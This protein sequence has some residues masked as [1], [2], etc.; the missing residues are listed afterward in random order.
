MKKS[1]ALMALTGILTLS[2]CGQNGTTP[3]TC[4]A[5]QV[6][7]NGVCVTPVT[8]RVLTFTVT[9]VSTAVP[10]TVTKTDGT[11]VGT[12]SVTNG[13]KLELPAGSYTVTP[14]AV[15]GYT[16]NGAQT[17]NLTEGNGTVTLAYAAAPGTQTAVLTIDLVG[18]ATAPVT[19]KDASGAVVS[20]Y[21]NAYV[22]DGETITLARGQYT[23]LGG[24]TMTAVAPTEAKAAD[25]R[26]GNAT[27][28]L[29]YTTNEART[30][31][32]Y[33]NAAGQRVYFNADP[34][35]LRADIAARKFRFSSWLENRD[36]GINVGNGTVT[37]VPTDAERTEYA[38]INTQNIVGAYT[39]YNDNGVWRPVVNSE[40]QM[41]ILEQRGNVRFA[42]ADDQDRSTM[43]ALDITSN[44]LSSRS[45][46][47]LSTD[48]NYIPYPNSATYPAYNRTGVAAPNTTGYTW[49]ALN[50]DPKFATPGADGIAASARIRAI[51]FV[52]GIEI[53]KQFLNKN[54]VASA[55]V[56]V[57]K[58]VVVLDQ[59]Q[60]DVVVR[61][62]DDTNPTYEPG[63]EVGIRI[64]IVN[65]GQAAANN[66]SLTDAVQSGDLQ[67]YAIGFSPAL[68]AY[69]RAQGFTNLTTT[70]DT[71]KATLPTLAAGE[72]RSIVFVA[73]GARDGTYCDT[74]T[75]DSYVNGLGQLSP[76]YV[77]T[78]AG[79][80]NR[81]GNPAAGLAAN[82][83]A[84]CFT[85]KG[86]PALSIVKEL[87]DANGRVIPNNTQV[88]RNQDVRIR[89]T[90]RN[91]GSG[92]AQGITVQDRLTSGD[93]AAHS[94]SLLGGEGT[95]TL[96]GNDGFN[97]NIGSLPAG[98]VAQYTFA[99]RG[100]VD[101]T[102]CDT[103]TLASTNVTPA[104]TTSSACFKVATA[105]LEISKTNDP[106]VDL[107]G[108]DSYTSTI[109]VRNTGTLAA[110]NIV[111]RDLLGRLNSNQAVQVNF[112]SGRYVLVV[113]DP[114]T[115]ELREETTPGGV[116]VEGAAPNA[117][118]RTLG[119]ATPDTGITL[120]PG[121]SIVL[122]VVS[123]IPAGTA[124]G[125]YCNVA[126]VTAAP[127]VV[128]TNN[129]AEACVSIV[130]RVAIQTELFDSV[131]L[132]A[133]AQ[134]TLF[135]AIGFNE[136]Q[137]TEDLINNVF[138]FNVGVPEG[139]AA[140][141][142]GVFTASGMKVYYDPTALDQTSGQ[143]I[144]TLPGAGTDTQD[145]TAQATIQPNP[146]TG[147]FTVNLPS[148][149]GIAPGGAVFVTFNGQAP[150]TATVGSYNTFMSWNS[151]GRVSGVAKTGT[152]QEDTTVRRQ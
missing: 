18:A 94:I 87:V 123:T 55:Q 23:V 79:H 96:Q 110:Q 126:T 95:A 138:S 92:V 100:S 99:A 48:P 21:N 135:T 133:P 40:V 152:S 144:F 149:F 57:I 140:N 113:R 145:I 61:S 19:I 9:G 76:A 51:G 150:A 16:N 62:L 64:R 29:N 42:A 132:I 120:N 74:A 12:Y 85:V 11:I 118:V 125:Q 71:F 41:E 44:A 2:A 32:F 131:D 43:P 45:W 114:A 77:D 112:A 91:G 117:T 89:V 3:V 68:Q 88:A 20:G 15:A 134:S 31:A 6:E 97:W 124:P 109:I 5:P 7:Q 127:N 49:A 39:E 35:K 93:A 146:A 58:E 33:V 50:H 36:G 102:Y 52:N 129:R 84:T 78:A 27:V 69:A 24:N 30:G 38:P 104:N 54:Y 101:G 17:V 143:V 136:N 46:T 65:R 22:R 90:V 83:D 1:I 122:N 59:R 66:I 106:R 73:T 10:V 128:F 111:V 142:A 107:A 80:I 98:G 56:E 47:N 8:Q 75:I 37:G 105:Q 141:A 139:A 14:S 116:V 67:N 119:R 148:N 53:D 130:P 137:S 151:N 103:V 70:D 13:Q 86:V 115:G 81:E 28:V 34:A 63:Q 60:T 4:T 108:G 26:N 121:E 147:R 25:L 82:V 72:T